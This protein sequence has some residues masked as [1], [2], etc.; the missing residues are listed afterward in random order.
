MI[1]YE[2]AAFAG[3]ALR[4][5][6]HFSLPPLH[7]SNLPSL[8]IWDANVS[9]FGHLLIRNKQFPGVGHT[10]RAVKTLWERKSL[11]CF[12]QGRWA[13]TKSPWKVKLNPGEWVGRLVT[14]HYQAG[15]KSTRKPRQILY[16]YEDF[17]KKCR[18][19]IHTHIE[20]QEAQ[21]ISKAVRT[22]WTTDT[23]HLHYNS[24]G[25]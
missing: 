22:V 18:A 11:T 23:L 8:Q 5:I 1:H 4:G 6:F 16:T 17:K 13:K 25:I 3:E 9:G 10:M 2:K 14:R 19:N 7:G 20:Y 15:W 12:K 21:G 24:N